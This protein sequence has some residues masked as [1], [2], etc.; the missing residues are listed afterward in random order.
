[1]TVNGVREGPS[2]AQNAYARLLGLRTL[3]AEPGRAEIELLL[4][5]EHLHDREIGHGGA[6]L[7]LVDQAVAVASNI[8]GSIAVV[9]SVSLQFLRRTGLGDRLTAIAEASRR[10]RT[11]SAYSVSVRR[12]GDDLVAQAQAQTMRVEP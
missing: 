4:G 9:C 1:M 5:A 12:E 10:G 3:S 8:E 11:L 7:A 6:I 2:S